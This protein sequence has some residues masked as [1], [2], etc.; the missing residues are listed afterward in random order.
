MWRSSRAISSIGAGDT[1]AI[2]AALHDD[3]THNLS[4]S[5]VEVPNEPGN[6]DELEMLAAAGTTTST[7]DDIFGGGDQ[8]AVRYTFDVAPEAVA[9]STATAPVT[10]TAISIVRIECGQTAEL[11]VESDT[12]AV[13]LAHGYTIE[14]AAPCHAPKRPI[15]SKGRRIPPRSSRARSRSRT[16]W[17]SLGHGDHRR[18]VQGAAD[19]RAHRRAPEHGLDLPVEMPNMKVEVLSSYDQIPQDA[20][21]GQTLYLVVPD[22]DELSHE[23]LSMVVGAAASCQSTASSFCTIP[24]CLSSSST[25]ST[26][27][28]T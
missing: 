6:A 28:C 23:E 20:I 15:P 2:D 14:T 16:R 19:G 12:V 9:G 18:I 1:A 21:N 11:W 24:S 25:A 13:L 10:T 7:I 27:S 26:N 4:R 3:F 17:P 8:V 5:G 22:T